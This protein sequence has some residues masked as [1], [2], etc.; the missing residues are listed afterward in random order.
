MTAAIAEMKKPKEVPA[1][2]QS[3][4]ELTS[5][6]IDVN[7]IVR[8]ETNR[9]PEV[10]DAFIDSIRKDGVMSAVLLRPIQAT[11]EHAEAWKPIDAPSIAVGETIY[12]LVYGERR[13]I[14]AK[15][16]GR[17]HIPA[18]IRELTDTKA[19]EIQ[20]AENE[21][22]EDYS[23]MDRAVAYTR[24]R[25]QYA[26]DHRGE[27]GWTEEKCM[28]QIASTCKND[29]I[30]GRTV[31][32][33]IA[34]G[35]LHTF[36]QAALR[37][38]EMEASHGYELCRRSEE[39]QL[40]LLKWIR[41]QTQHSQGDVPSV[42]R[43]KLE[44]RNMDIAADEKRRQEKLFKDPQPGTSS[45]PV[46]TIDDVMYQ[47]A[48]GHVRETGAQVRYV[49]NQ[50]LQRRLSIGY[51]AAQQLL[52]RMEKEGI[53]GAEDRKAHWPYIFPKP[54]A[55]AQTSAPPTST[56]ASRA[57]ILP[58]PSAKKQ[59]ATKIAEQL[60]KQ[61]EQ[62][63]KADQKR[64]GSIEIEKQV[65]YAAMEA[66]AKKAK[67]DRPLI[68]EVLVEMLAAGDDAPAQ[69]AV[70]AFGWTKPHSNHFSYN[71]I[72]AVAQKNVPKMKPN[73]VAALLLACL[74]QEE[75]DVYYPND[76]CEKL[77]AMARKYKV[78]LGKIRKD[79]ATAAKKKG[80]ATA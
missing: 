35:K 6:M 40:E 3:G 38:G 47:N 37:Q 33:I 59:A 12:K 50:L 29:K 31:Q 16:A 2:I 77:D 48:V 13:W 42:R 45:T 75:L 60:R 54:A 72:R 53:V 11:K 27:K 67:L 1:E 18:Q 24:L 28:D 21:H 17:T 14:A 5:V 30:K 8:S 56:V 23:V 49:T 15:K 36:C 34:L 19:L 26:E 63:A 58:Q 52:L 39:E 32:Q 69:F 44:I 55:T 43:L 46:P 9:V 71:E 73:Q 41:Q 80:G 10:S 65:R 25:M 4:R 79:L 62:E 78:N 22:R 74:V 20:I 64:K 68:N 76:K 70:K 51:T 57:G 7:K 61:R 66:I